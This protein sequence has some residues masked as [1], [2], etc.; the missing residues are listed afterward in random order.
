MQDRTGS[1][2]GEKPS[3]RPALGDLRYKWE[4]V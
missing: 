3:G 1:V 4:D 2:V